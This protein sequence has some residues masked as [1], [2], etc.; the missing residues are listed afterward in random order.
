ML[1]HALR[2]VQEFHSSCPPWNTF[3]FS[4]TNGVLRLSNANHS[5]ST[6]RVVSEQEPEIAHLGAQLNCQSRNVI[7][8]E[9][10]ANM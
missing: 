8:R 5:H 9:E 1:T 6:C 10:N 2:L 7:Q 4:L 3:V